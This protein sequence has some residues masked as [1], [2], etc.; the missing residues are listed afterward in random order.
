MSALTLTF[1]E[2]SAQ[3]GFPAAS[4]LREAQAHGYVVRVGRSKR[5]LAAEVGELLEKC[6]CQPRAR[7]LPNE[8]ELDGLRSTSSRMLASKSARAQTIAQKLKSNL[9]NTSPAKTAQ[10]VPLKQAN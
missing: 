7:D 3:T 2:V 5:M 10:V 6:R 1:A 8:S 9:P 4:L